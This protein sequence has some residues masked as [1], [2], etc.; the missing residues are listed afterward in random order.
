M[1][2]YITDNR[3]LI[4]FLYIWIYREKKTREKTMNKLA[5]HIIFFFIVLSSTFV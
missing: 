5:L 3:L 4:T 2:I 1:E